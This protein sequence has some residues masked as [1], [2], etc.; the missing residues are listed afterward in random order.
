MTDPILEG[1]RSSIEEG[2]SDPQ[3]SKPEPGRPTAPP[4]PAILGI[5]FAEKGAVVI[6]TVGTAVLT[7]DERA[8]IGSVAIKAFNRML[9]S[10]LSEVRKS[11]G[12]K[13]RTRKNGTKSPGRPKLPR[14]EQGNIIRTNDPNAGP[15]LPVN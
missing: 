7:A 8:K 6:T 3:E 13:R 12:V 9:D 1:M 4:Q 2:P 10:V 11:T 5:E 14:D 15:T